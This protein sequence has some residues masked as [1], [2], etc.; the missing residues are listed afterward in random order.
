MSLEYT[1][2]ILNQEDV[3]EYKNFGMKEWALHFSEYGNYDGSHH[4]QWTIDQMVR[5]LHGTKVLIVETT[6]KN[7]NVIVDTQLDEPSQEYLDYVID[8]CDGEEGPNTYDYDEGIA[9]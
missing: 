8:F 5:I 1:Q 6:H 7:G 4:K 2:K 9:P 3:P